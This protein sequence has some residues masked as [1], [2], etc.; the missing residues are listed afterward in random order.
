M[1]SV[2]IPTYNRYSFLK[3]AVQSVLM[4]SLKDFELII[5][6]DGSTDET[7]ELI[8]SFSD[9]R[10]RYF[11]Q[12]NKG[13]SSA[14]NKG[15][16]ESR[17]DLIAFLDSDDCWKEK[18]LEK[19]LKFM[20][21]ISSI[22]SHT[23]E[24]WY[25][26]GKIL[27]QKKKHRK[28]A[29]EL[30]E[31]SL[32]MCSISISTAMVRKSLFDDV[33]LFDESLPACEDYDMWLRVTSKYSVNLLD[34]ELTVKDGGRTDQ[35]SQRIPMQDRF[36]IQAIIKLFEADALN[37]AQSTFAVKALQK[38]CGIYIDGCRKHGRDEEA[39]KYEKMLEEMLDL[40][41][42]VTVHGSGFKVQ[43]FQR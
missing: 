41:S 11:F 19:Q 6:D 14:R 18:K 30:F 13:V 4:Q 8:L 26:R 33:G 36:R 23:Q 21:N 43:G 35:L 1:I 24:L 22:I 34:E 5:V 39:I 7:K 3:K 25:R 40:F 27:N 42:L 16:I 28:C 20:E 9:E 29:G 32:E 31:K 2:I 10:I 15:V 38:K 17:G 12:E 37:R